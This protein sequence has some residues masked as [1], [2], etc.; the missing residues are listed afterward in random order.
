MHL[1]NIPTIKFNNWSTHLNIKVIDKILILLNA[2]LICYVYKMD[3]HHIQLHLTLKKC[4][5]S[6]EILIFMLLHILA[7]T[8]R[9]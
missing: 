9:N 1:Y 4:T 8:S 6:D 2:N 5:M 7:Y 3:V